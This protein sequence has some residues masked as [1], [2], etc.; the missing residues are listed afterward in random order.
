MSQRR[1]RPEEHA[2][3]AQPTPRPSD[4]AS[5]RLAASL[6]HNTAQYRA[7]TTAD[8]TIVDT[9]LRMDDPAAASRA[10]AGSTA[11]LESL[12]NQLRTAVAEATVEREAESVLDA[13]V[14]DA[15]VPAPA[16]RGWRVARSLAGAVAAAAM[17]V[18]LLVPMGRQTPET[19]LT[20]VQARVA[21]E[22]LTAAHQQVGR[23][24]LASDADIERNVQ[25][26]HARLRAVPEAAL[27]AVSVR[28]RT[29]TRAILDEERAELADRPARRAA[30]LLEEADAIEARFDSGPEAGPDPAADGLVDLTT[31]RAPAVGADDKSLPP[32]VPIQPGGEAGPAGGNG[33]PVADP[34]DQNLPGT[35]HLTD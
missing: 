30:A 14:L 2:S 16:P 6:H 18:A 12:M 8:L 5:R 25:A 1:L 29:R 34:L 3:A 31:A 26:L 20:A 33:L 23:L 28:T 17:A 7:A 19:E 35:G 10:L 11:A 24:K 32:G 21:E 4:T 13:V 27:T 9:L 22:N 15:R